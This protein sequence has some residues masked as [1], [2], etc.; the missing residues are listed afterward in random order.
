MGT[1]LDRVAGGAGS[2]TFIFTST[3]QSPTTSIDVISDFTAGADVIVFQDM[4]SGTFNWM[5]TSSSA[6]TF[7][8]SGSSQAYFRTSNSTLYV[9]SDGNGVADMAVKLES[10]VPTTLSAADFSW[11]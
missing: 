4:L 3:T 7:S 11:L 8:N 6:M 1:G 5:G 2:D 9:D 10:V